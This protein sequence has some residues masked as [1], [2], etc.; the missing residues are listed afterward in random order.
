MPGP[1]STS[2]RSCIAGPNNT[3]DR[4]CRGFNNAITNGFSASERRGGWVVGY[5]TE[6]ALTQNWSAKAEYNYI[7][8]GDRDNAF[9]NGT[10]LS[11]RL[12]I[13]E[14]KIGV[15]YRFAPTVAAAPI[16]PVIS[17]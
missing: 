17:K 14:V 8:F 4:T 16:M 11:D 3:I 10:F 2:A 1:T 5:G 13:S 15:N 9:N 6:F 7:G 12:R